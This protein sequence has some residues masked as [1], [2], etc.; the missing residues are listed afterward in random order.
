M[1]GPRQLSLRDLNRTTLARQRLLERHWATPAEAVGALAGLQAQHAN[2]PY[3]AL[4]SRVR[5]FSIADLEAAIEDRSVVKATVVRATLHLVAATDFHALD[6]AAAEARIANWRPTATRAGL[7]M[8][9]L[10]AALLEYCREPR[11]VAEMETHLDRLA[12]DSHLKKHM[13][14]GVRHVAFRI[15]SAG[16]GLVHVP[17]SGLWRSHGKPRYIDARVW[18]PRERRPHP[19][20]ALRSAVERYLTAYGPASLADIGKWVGQPRVSTVRAAVAALDDRIMALRDPDGRDLV[21]LAG[22]SVRDGKRD[23]PV[24]FLAR[25]D[26]ALIGYDVRDRILP[27]AY[28]AAVIKKNG[29]FLPTFLVDGMV[30]GLWA[31]D[32]ARDEAVLTITPFGTVSAAFRRDL[33]AEAERLVRFVEPEAARHGLAWTPGP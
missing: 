15:A 6:A 5:D 14:A 18:L 3:I 13:P 11:T 27:E 32:A 4:W 33:E 26:S 24:R 8:D 25:W 9:G 29:D 17:P 19:D 12:P 7:D 30:A 31:V 21:D 23:A 10:N 2:S 20:Q 1:S 28:R 22:L 16:G